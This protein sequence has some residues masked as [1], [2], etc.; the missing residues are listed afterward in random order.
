LKNSLEI[1]PHIPADKIIISESG[2]NM[3]NDIETL[4]KAG[5]HAFLIGETLMRSEN[6]G[7]KLSE[8][9]GKA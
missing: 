6:I 7:K 1:A 8:L 5:I 4:M 3:R 9:L 2:I